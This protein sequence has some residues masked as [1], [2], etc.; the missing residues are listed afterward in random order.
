MPRRQLAAPSPNCAQ[1][2]LR[3]KVRTIPL[4]QI[5]LRIE[6]IAAALLELVLAPELA[7]ERASRRLLGWWLLVPRGGCSLT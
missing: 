7:L 4:H 2:I 3:G 6:S 5:E 1:A